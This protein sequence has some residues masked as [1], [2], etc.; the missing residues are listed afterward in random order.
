MS[1][2]YASYERIATVETYTYT[3]TVVT[4]QGQSTAT[5]TAR[6]D[7][8]CPRRRELKCPGNCRCWYTLHYNTNL[9]AYEP[10]HCN[11]CCIALYDIHFVPAVETAE[12]AT[13]VVAE[14]VA[15]EREVVAGI[16][17]YKQ[18]LEVW[19]FEFDEPYRPANEEPS[20]EAL[21]LWAADTTPLNLDE[22]L[23]LE[24]PPVWM[25]ENATE[26][27]PGPIEEPAPLKPVSPDK[28]QYFVVWAP[29]LTND[30]KR[31]GLLCRKSDGL[32]VDCSCGDR[33]HRGRRQ[34]RACKHQSAHN[35]MLT[36][37]TQ[38]Q[39]AA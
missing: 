33:V 10:V 4:E 8:D 11:N 23:A 25:C 18:V 20:E 6:A 39:Q 19:D 36:P 3:A 17:H 21:A 31:Y 1:T 9:Q 2:Q 13:Q 5:L 16:E 24:Q 7:L 22:P 29:S 30:K 34:G 38:K 27:E 15:S 37:A 14:P 35:A 32:A 26:A 28:K 12:P